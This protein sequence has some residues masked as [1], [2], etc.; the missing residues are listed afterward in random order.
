MNYDR[1]IT[2]SVGNNRMSKNWQPQNILLS[3]FYEKLRI[4]NRS[5]E[6]LNEYL[7]LKKSEQDEKKDIGGFVA[8][9]LSGPR[10]K[11]GAVVGRDLI[12]LDFDNMFYITIFRLSWM[13]LP[14][15][16]IPNWSLNFFWRLTRQPSQQEVP[17][18]L[19][20]NSCNYVTVRFTMRTKYPFLFTIV[21]LMPLW[22][23]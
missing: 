3:E 9:S 16:P 19:P 2:I 10:R 22:N 6:T 17:E 18:F 1:V 14:K 13:F 8:G 11:A 21:K 20:E 15:K 7:N 5:T 23:L 4:P 12:T